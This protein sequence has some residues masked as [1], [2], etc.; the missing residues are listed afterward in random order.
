MKDTKGAM[1][2]LIRRMR[3]KKPR[4][5]AYPYF[6]SAWGRRRWIHYQMSLGR[7]GPHASGA[8]TNCRKGGPEVLGVAEEFDDICKQLVN[9]RIDTEEL[10]NRLHGG[11]AVPLFDLPPIETIRTIAADCTPRIL[12]ASQKEL[13]Q[14][15]LLRVNLSCHLFLVDEATRSP[16]HRV[17][18]SQPDVVTITVRRQTKSPTFL[19][20]KPTCLR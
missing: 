14:H 2:G 8:L 10:K 1:P 16:L 13:S 7:G 17:L 11:I 5:Q 3:W 15:P 20:K 12:V 4:R 18:V 19:R 6:T 9:N